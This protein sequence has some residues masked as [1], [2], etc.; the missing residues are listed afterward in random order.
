M[1]SI[2]FVTGNKNKLAEVQAILQGTI[3]VESVSVDVPELQGTIEDIAR[4]K[5]RKAAEAV[6]GPALTDDT[7]LEFN[8]LNGL[9]GPYIKWFLEKLGHVGLN[10]LVEPYEDKSAVTV[11]TFAF[12][13]GPGQEPILFQGRTEVS[14]IYKD[15]Y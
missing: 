13:A 6:N 4:E 8:A 5:C 14:E 11:A 9:P 15:C 1:K 3:E 10:K 7:A 2:N 12:C